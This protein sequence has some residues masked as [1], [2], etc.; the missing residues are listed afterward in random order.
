VSAVRNAVA[1]ARGRAAERRAEQHLRAAGL[2]TVARNWRCRGGELDLVMRDGASLVFVEVRARTRNDFASAAESV[3]PRKQA[4]LVHA[5][6]A[7]LQTLSELP[8]CRFD[9]VTVERDAGSAAQL[10]WIRDAFEAPR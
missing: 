6:E 2:V 1:R 9:V 4:R 5:A 3:G 8:P 7:F 10:A